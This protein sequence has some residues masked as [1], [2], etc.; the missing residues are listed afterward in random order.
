LACKCGKLK[1][2]AFG[3]QVDHVLVHVAVEGDVVASIRIILEEVE[4]ESAFARARRPCQHDSTSRAGHKKPVNG[5]LELSVA[6]AHHKVLVSL[7]LGR[8]FDTC[9]EEVGRKA[10]VQL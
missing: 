1:D 6:L 2:V 9:V 10:P 7:S 3:E 8:K 5:F 4:Q